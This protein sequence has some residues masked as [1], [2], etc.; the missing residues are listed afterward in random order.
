MFGAFLIEDGIQS[1]MLK[2]YISASNHVL[3]TDGYC[4]NDAEVKI[5]SLAR[6][7]K[8]VNDVMKV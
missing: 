1:S 8:L 2:S 3:I 5:N 7:C 4:W 6:N